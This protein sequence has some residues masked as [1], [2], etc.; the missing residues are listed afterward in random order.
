MSAQGVGSIRRA[1]TICSKARSPPV[2]SPSPRRVQAVLMTPISRP[3]LREVISGARTAPP[4]PG[5]L[6]PPSSAGP[7]SRTCRPA[8]SRRR[9]RCI[10]A[11]GSA[12][13]RADPR[14][15]TIRRTP[16]SSAT[17]CTAVAPEAV[18]TLRRYGLTQQ[19]L[20]PAQCPTTTT[21]PA[22]FQR[23]TPPRKRNHPKLCNSGLTPRLGQGGADPARA[24]QLL[25]CAGRCSRRISATGA[26]T[27]PPWGKPTRSA[28]SRPPPPARADPDAGSP[29]RRAPSVVVPGRSPATDPNP[30]GRIPA[31]QGLGASPQPLRPRAAN[32]PRA[33]PGRPGRPGVNRIARPPAHR[34]A[35]RLRA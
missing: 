28:R 21:P 22:P 12:S 19:I 30:P 26:H 16:F 23:K 9:P 34:G 32:T 35:S 4:S 33:G 20:P 6:P 1:A 11:A 7:G 17:T 18:L 5:A 15:S 13:S 24:P 31:A 8:R 3:D 27:P 29:V 25:P 10:S 14:C 2:A